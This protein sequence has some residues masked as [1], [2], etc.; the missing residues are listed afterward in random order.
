LEVRRRPLRPEELSRI[1][2]ALVANSHWGGRI[3][4]TVLNL[5]MP[6]RRTH[7]RKRHYDADRRAGYVEEWRTGVRDAIC[8]DRFDDEP[9]H[10]RYFLGL[11]DGRVLFL[12]G[13]YLSP[14][15]SVGRFP[16]TELMLVR[17][18]HSRE[19][20]DITCLGDHLS[21]SIFRPPFTVAEH[22]SGA[23]PKDGDL[24][25]GPISRFRRARK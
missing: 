15:E 11:H 1:D 21:T 4:S 16:C 10:P 22:L 12:A 18:P 3:V 20:I 19:I 5:L 23:V 2:E 14:L 13:D 24:L 6:S 17:L 25:E 7:D 8:V 9:D